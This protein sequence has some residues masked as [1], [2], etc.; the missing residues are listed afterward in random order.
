MFVPK[1]THPSPSPSPE[2]ALHRSHFSPLASPPT[3]PPRGHRP[4]ISKPMTWLGRSSTSGSS[5]SAPCAAPKPIRISEPKFDNSLEI[6]NVKRGGALGSGAIIVRTPQ[7]ALACSAEQ[8][9]D[10][11][12]E[13][14][15]IRAGAGVYNEEHEQEQGVPLPPHSPPPPPLPEKSFTPPLITSCR[16]SPISMSKSSPNLLLRESSTPPCPIRPPPPVPTRPLPATVRSSLKSK[17]TT[18]LEQSPPVP[19]LPSN[20]PASSPPPPFEAILLSS[21]PNSAIDPSKIIITLETSTM[22]HRTTLQTLNSRPSFLASYITSLFPR[23]SE[24]ASLHSHISDLSNTPG[25]SFNALFHDHLTSSG[26]LPHSSSNIHIFLDRPSAP[27]AHILTYLRSP[28]SS[29]EHPAILPRAAQLVSS[30][31]SRL[32]ALLELRDEASYLDLDELYKLCN[33]EINQRQN[34]MTLT[35]MRVASDTSRTS[36]HSLHTFR[37]RNGDMATARLSSLSSDTASK[38][39][40]PSLSVTHQPSLRGRSQTRKEVYVLGSTRTSPPAGWI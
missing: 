38:G 24:T 15:E 9:F 20:I 33:D 19:A 22:T 37:E 21:V 10:F 23:K 34:I 13:E 3:T 5:H 31:R 7:E 4:S 8:L 11:L 6:F 39:T 2:L 40:H 35:H 17:S 28:P 27:Y 12:D 18:S 26:L 30:F 32:E 25:E 14:E 1:R 29:P 36:L 16:A